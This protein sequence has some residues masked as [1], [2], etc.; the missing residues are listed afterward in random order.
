MVALNTYSARQGL[1]SNSGVQE[2]EA[3]RI[4]EEEEARLAVEKEQR[5]ADRAARRAEAKRQGLLLTG[6]AKKEAERLAAIREQL[7]RD[8]GVD[9]GGAS[10]SK[11]PLRK[12]ACCVASAFG[13]DLHHLVYMGEQIWQ[14]SVLMRTVVHIAGDDAEKPAPKKVVYGKKKPAKK[15]SAPGDSAD[16]A[17]LEEQAALAERQAAEESTRRAQ[18]KAQ[19]HVSTII[20]VLA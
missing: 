5:K 9:V 2:E 16:K 19:L 20:I 8:S 18:V 10:P 7:L 17:A 15:D 13:K 6:K 12:C 3:A 4:A 14:L 11:A 1:S